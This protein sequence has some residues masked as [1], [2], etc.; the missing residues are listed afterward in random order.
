MTVQGSAPHRMISE[1]TGKK[2]KRLS[3][4]NHIFHEGMD[5]FT[6]DYMYLP[7]NSVMTPSLPL[8]TSL[9]LAL[10]LLPT[11]HLLPPSQD[12]SKVL[13]FCFNHIQPQGNNSS[14]TL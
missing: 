6:K 5:V 13:W 12:R 1:F 3:G 4:V 10:S 9:P 7:A 2:K 14:I 8:P 11:T